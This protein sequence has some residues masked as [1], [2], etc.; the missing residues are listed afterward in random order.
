MDFCQDR[1]EEE[2][3]IWSGKINRLLEQRGLKQVDMCRALKIP[4]STFNDWTAG[5]RPVSH[6]RRIEVA[7]FFGYPTSDSLFC[8]NG[9]F[10]T[11]EIDKLKEKIRKLEYQNYML[12]NQMTLPCMESEI[13]KT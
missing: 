1:D 5:V 2:R 8:N 4:V 9:T 10:S 11:D 7:K 12:E 6:Y 13:G 3:A